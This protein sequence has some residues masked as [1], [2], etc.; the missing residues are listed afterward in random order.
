MTPG[1]I[2][3]PLAR[4]ERESKRERSG[5]HVD[6]S[7]Y[8]GS[9]MSRAALLRDFVGPTLLHARKNQLDKSRLCLIRVG[10]R[11]VLPDEPIFPGNSRC[12]ASRQ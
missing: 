6:C 11:D 5:L 9:L 12:A 3:I 1:S 10:F 8:R 4:W 2:V 7:S